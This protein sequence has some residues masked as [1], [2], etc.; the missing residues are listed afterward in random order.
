MYCYCK[1]ITEEHINE[2]GTPILEANNLLYPYMNLLTEQNDMALL[3]PRNVFLDDLVFITG[4]N[5]RWNIKT[6]A[7]T[8]NLSDSG[9]NFSDVSTFTYDGIMKYDKGYLYDMGISTP[10]ST[11]AEIDAAS[12]IVNNVDIG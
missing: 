9:L 4:I 7:T 5:H 10:Q 6:D 3:W 2:F 8:Y 11:D 1:L 12:V